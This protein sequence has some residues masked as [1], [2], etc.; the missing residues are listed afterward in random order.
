M[1]CVVICGIRRARPRGWPP[2]TGRHHD[3]S[4]PPLLAPCFRPCFSSLTTPG[5]TLVRACEPRP[6]AP[7]ASRYSKNSAT[8]DSLRSHFV[9][10]A[11]PPPWPA[12]RC[13]C[14]PHALH[15]AP[16]LQEQPRGG[17]FLRWGLDGLVGRAKCC[18]GWLAPACRSGRI[19]I[20]VSDGSPPASCR[21]HLVYQLQGPRLV[22]FR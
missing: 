15:P 8:R 21:A 7:G 12:H 4:P 11:C 6:V 22:L 2:V 9:L 20:S 17:R 5:I 1:G 3:T 16:L 19:D 10:L 13:V 14:L 18:T